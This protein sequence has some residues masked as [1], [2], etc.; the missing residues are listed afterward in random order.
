MLRIIWSNDRVETLSP[1]LLK[2]LRANVPSGTVVYTLHLKKP[3]TIVDVTPAG[4]RVET[5]RS[6]ES[7]QGPQ[8][9]EA[10][11]LES[12]WDHLQSTGSLT[13]R[14]LLDTRKL[15]VKRSSAV[16]AILAC[17]P[18]VVVRSTSPIRLELR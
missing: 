12:A 3:N 11:M 1:E 15:N 16:C 18:D 10:W 8:L 4:I 5:E 14:E 13:N 2:L 7:G 6:L 9:V 17:L